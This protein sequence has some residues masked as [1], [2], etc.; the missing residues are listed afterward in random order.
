MSQKS[1][2]TPD[3][4]EALRLQTKTLQD[5]IMALEIAVLKHA[6]VR[7][8]F[9]ILISSIRRRAESLVV[10]LSNLYHRGEK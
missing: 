2:M 5:Q 1:P 10:K 6:T 8:E 4:Y 9:I 7:S 3:E